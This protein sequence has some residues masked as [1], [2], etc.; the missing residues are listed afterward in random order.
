M[1]GWYT[2]ETSHFSEVKGG[3]GG[4]ANLRGNGIIEGGCDP[5]IK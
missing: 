1:V 4:G 5:D 2:E 3:D